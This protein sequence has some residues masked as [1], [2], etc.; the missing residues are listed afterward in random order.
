MNQNIYLAM[1]SMTTLV[2]SNST[3]DI[4]LN[5]IKLT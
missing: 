3:D 2:S 5:E 1:A 4:T